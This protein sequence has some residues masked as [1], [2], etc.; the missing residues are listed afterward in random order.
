M[1][2]RMRA[3]RI[4]CLKLGVLTRKGFI[5]LLRDPVLLLLAAFLFTVNIYMQGSTLSMQLNS[6]PLLVHDADRSGA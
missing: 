4:W 5:Q 6:A 1:N 3:A 2:A